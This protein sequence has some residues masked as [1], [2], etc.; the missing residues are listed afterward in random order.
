M[1]RSLLVL[2]F[3][4]VLALFGAGITSPTHAQAPKG[5]WLITDYPAVTVR[6]GETASIRMKLQNAGLAPER[7]ALSVQGLPA[8]WKAQIMGGGQP[9]EAAMPFTNDSV[10]LELRLDIPR[11]QTSGTFNL[12]VQA[13]GGATSASLPLQVTLGQELPA[14]LTLKP[15]LPSLKGTVRASFDY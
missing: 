8:G 12:G 15:K 11:E 7:M 9:V 4:L 2:S 5:L 3:S 6:A 10:S 13:R 1:R 14:K